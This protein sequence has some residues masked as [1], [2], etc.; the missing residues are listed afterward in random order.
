M[1][2]PCLQLIP[3]TGIQQQEVNKLRFILKMSL[4][5]AILLYYLIL[6][7]FNL[8]MSLSEPFRI[9]IFV[10]VERFFF[11]IHPQTLTIRLFGILVMEI[12]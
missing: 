10:L 5:A 4:D 6:I 11:E 3:T 1:E 8:S 2:I 9:E 7:I 12:L